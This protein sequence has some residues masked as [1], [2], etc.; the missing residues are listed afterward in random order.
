MEFPAGLRSVRRTKSLNLAGGQS[1]PYVFLKSA[2]SETFANARVLCRIRLRNGHS[3]PFGT[4]SQTPEGV[5]QS[6][7]S[8]RGGVLNP[9]GIPS[10]S[11]G[12]AFCSQPWELAEND[13]QP[14]RGCGQGRAG[15]KV[16]PLQGCEMTPLYPGLAGKRQPWALLWN[17]F[18]IHGVGACFSPATSRA[19]VAVRMRDDRGYALVAL[20]AAMSL[21]ALA[22]LAVVPTVKQQDQ[23]ER[24]KEAIFRGE[25]VAKA[26]QIYVA[27]QGARRGNSPQAI[28][29][30]LPT[31]MDQLTEGVTIGS[32]K[33]QI[34]R[35]EAAHDPL[36]STGEWRLISPTSQDFVQFVQAVTVF[37]GGTLPPTRGVMAGF[38]PQ[39]SNVL[40]TGSTSTAPGGEDTSANSSG[41]FIGVAS[42]SQRNS[43][44]TYYG[45]DRHDE[46]IFTPIFR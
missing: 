15:S 13:C 4:L 27:A 28:A 23:R 37:S 2:M 26:I 36:S 22:L 39:L 40:N 11:P 18:G 25:E 43:V 9:K 10:Q 16:Q 7:S 3:N 21:M 31:S 33:I 46:W 32:R 14:Q 8:D 1:M 19:A 5:K 24:E 34:L 20:L 17:P 29:S 44:L 38:V 30:S 12:L 6:T 35:P 45:I 42:R 41:P